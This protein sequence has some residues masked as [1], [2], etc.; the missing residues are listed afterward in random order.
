MNDFIK[1]NS[2]KYDNSIHKSWTGELISLKDDLIKIKAIFDKDI[3]HPSLGF[4]NKQTIAYEYFWLNKW[5]NIFRFHQPDGKLRNWYCN[6][7]VPP[8]Y[9]DCTIDYVDLDIDIVVWP[10]FK[11]EILD[12]D[13][14]ESN[15]NYYN[16]SPSIRTKAL[17]TMKEIVTAIK[18]RQFPFEYG[19]TGSL[20]S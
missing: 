7:C 17:E 18:K 11:H 10:D 8:T 15:T 9:S 4:I 19:I 13:E 2:R 6:I 16:Y 5:F 12:L 20:S 1:V 3:D 14:F